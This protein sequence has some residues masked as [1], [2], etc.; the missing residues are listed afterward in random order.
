M[1]QGH[2]DA[3]TLSA[4]L[5]K[6]VMSVSLGP[7]LTSS[8][9]TVSLRQPPNL[10]EPSFSSSVK[11]VAMVVRGLMPRALLFAGPPCKAALDWT[12]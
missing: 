5:L 2:K 10:S 8:S 6:R 11:C 12:D 9:G 7:F 4:D 1:L 3:G